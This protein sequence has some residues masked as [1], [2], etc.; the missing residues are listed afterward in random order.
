MGVAG[1][2]NNGS[3][4]LSV[5]DPAHMRQ[6]FHG[7]QGPL[8]EGL[9]LVLKLQTERPKEALTLSSFSKESARRGT[10]PLMASPATAASQG[11]HPAATCSPSTAFGTVP[12]TCIGW[13]RC[14]G[15]SITLL[16]S[17]S[18]PLARIGP[19]PTLFSTATTCAT[20]STLT[21]TTSS[22]IN[23]D[24]AAAI[25]FAGA[26]ACKGAAAA[27]SREAG[28]LWRG[29]PLLSSMTNGLPQA[30]PMG[31]PGRSTTSWLT[32]ARSA[33]RPPPPRRRP[34]EGMPR[35]TPK[36]WREDRSARQG[37]AARPGCGFLLGIPDRV[38][39]GFFGGGDRCGA[40]LLCSA[41]LCSLS[42]IVFLLG[43]G[44]TSGRAKK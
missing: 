18:I 44:R 39:F 8:I 21:P 26:S 40:S 1:V 15:L 31:S 42:G 14:A 13:F 37:S 12:M 2:P 33:P 34:S 6:Q 23:E 41:Q 28:S 29:L 38:F 7:L 30:Q 36:P 43:H 25:L 4:F 16:L 32:A 17:A 22:R 20:A 35:A 27:G 24:T 5:H 10:Q 19:L 11:G 3:C 9:Q